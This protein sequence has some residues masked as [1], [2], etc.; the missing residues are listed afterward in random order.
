PVYLAAST[1]L[2]WRLGD[3][4]GA[5]QYG[6]YAAASTTAVREAQFA[7]VMVPRRRG[8]LLA[9]GDFELGLSGWTIRDADGQGPNHSASAEQVHGGQRSGRIDQA[10]YLY[11]SR[12][13]LPVGAAFTARAWYRTEGA[14][15]GAAWQVFF[16][17]AGNKAFA[18]KRID[19]LKSPA[20]WS[21]A[22]LEA[23][24]PPGTAT[25][26]VAFNYFDTGV[27]YVDDVAIDAP[28]VPAVTSGTGPVEVTPAPDLL[29]GFTIAVDGWRH[30]VS[31]GRAAGL[32][33]DGEL[34][35]VSLDPA[36]V[37][38]RALLYRGTR[39]RYQ[40]KDL[41]TAKQPA[42]VTL[43]RDAAG[44]SAVVQQ[45]LSPGVPP[46]DPASVGCLVAR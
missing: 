33:T 16:W 44:W 41:V 6:P 40:G 23:V 30:V 9:N 45:D 2:T 14:T 7:A 39:L 26:S 5:E 42:T 46:V 35:A 11:S 19:G 18:N 25:I 8:G 37:P 32:E 34:A 28:G 31:R 29:S 17:D 12:F 3:Y 13:S 1:P 36:G 22:V 4:P 43:L 20:G 27:G 21:E 24:V 10:G 15:R 38:V